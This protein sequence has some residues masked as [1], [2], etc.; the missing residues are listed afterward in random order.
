MAKIEKIHALE[1]LDSR[2]FPTLEIILKTDTQIITKAK[3]PSGASTGENEALELRDKDKNRYAGKGVLKAVYN[4]NN[5]L[6]NL[7][8][9]KDVLLQEEIDRLMITADGTENKSHFGA[10]AILGVSLAVARAGAIEKKLPL[11]RYLKNQEKYYLPC[12]M[13]NVING[14]EHA[15]N[16][17]DIQEFMI[18]P[19][20][21]PSFK[22]ALRW[23]AEIFHTLKSLL[24]EAGH[25]TSV[26][27]EG[28]FAPNLSSD[29]E[30]LNLLVQAIEKAGYKP[31]EQVS[32][33]L[34]LAASEFYDK[35]KKLYFEKKNK[36]LG[37]PYKTRDTKEQIAYIEYL[38]KKF[39]ISS[40]ED[41][42]DENDWK[43]WSLFTKEM[44]DKIQI[45]GDDL[46]VTN[47]KFLKRGIEEKSAN[48]ILVKLNQ[49]GTL[50]ETIETINL[51]KENDFSTI[52]S[53]RSAET[54]DDFIADLAVGLTAKQIKTG[55]LSRSERIC[56]YN[57]LLEIEE[58]L[59]D[60]AVYSHTLGSRL[61]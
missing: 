11:Y 22:E 56:K 29:E 3:I 5:H 40:I 35:K 4:V 37:K 60:R 55:S 6:N 31:G 9:G 14:G 21:A 52:I 33:A 1:I 13:M 49:I 26:G 8:K 61:L 7:L 10:N 19:I 57:R 54:E 28:G 53:H 17:L 42:L 20:G 38:V 51:A 58:E 23:G 47:V 44:G 12:P 45:I 30:A 46:F 24:K 27:D 39:P 15:D 34:D 59:G 32:L 48:A 50:T 25:E 2:G 18:R 43:G 36:L 16:S 41:G